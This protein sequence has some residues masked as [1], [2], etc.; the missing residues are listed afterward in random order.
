M[1]APSR[2]SLE[3]YRERVSIS[4]AGIHTWR[5]H[6]RTWLSFDIS[7]GFDVVLMSIEVGSLVL[8]RDNY[9]NI[10]EHIGI[11]YHID[12]YDNPD[13]GYKVRWTDHNGAIRDYY[14]KFELELVL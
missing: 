12:Y 6:R 2:S 3:C 1:L 4:F 9:T 10:I 7:K 8:F 13:C 14:A 11:V 5:C